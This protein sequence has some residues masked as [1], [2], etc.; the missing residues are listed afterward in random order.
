MNCKEIVMAHY[1]LRLPDSLKT[2]AKRL[3]A[4]DDTTM[5]QLFV[6]AIAE[7]ISALEASAFFERRGALADRSGADAVGGKVGEQ[8]PLSGDDWARPV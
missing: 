6:V 1:K 7:K 2:A 3:A 5:N 8:S 4:A